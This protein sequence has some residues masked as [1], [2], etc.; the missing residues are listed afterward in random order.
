MTCNLSNLQY[1]MEAGLNKNQV[2]ACTQPRRVA[3][4]TIAQ[5]VAA[6]KK[7]QLGQ[8]VSGAFVTDT[9]NNISD[10]YP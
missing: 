7:T 8:L 2:I 5:R 6:E 1:L 9:V 3:A 10:H 4:I